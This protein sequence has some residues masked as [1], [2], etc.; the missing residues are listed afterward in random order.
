MTDN[1]SDGQCQGVGRND[2]DSITNL[3]YEGSF[4]ITLN[5]EEDPKS[6]WQFLFS[7]R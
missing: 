5:D 4:N 6:F 2:R 3:E 1:D 7:D